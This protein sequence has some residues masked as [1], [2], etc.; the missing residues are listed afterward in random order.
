MKLSGNIRKMKSA[1]ADVV[2]YQL[3]LYDIL[4]PN[5]YIPLNELV[6]Q[7]IRITFESAIHCVI[8]GKKINKTFGDGMSYDAFMNSPEASPSIIRPHS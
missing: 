2:Q 1:L 8:S 3:P 5:H 7:K 6:G 4:S